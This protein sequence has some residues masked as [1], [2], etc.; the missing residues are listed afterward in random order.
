MR[1]LAYRAGKAAQWLGELEQ[2]I[3]IAEARRKLHDVQQEFE[4]V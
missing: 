4:P 2:T 3:A 1:C